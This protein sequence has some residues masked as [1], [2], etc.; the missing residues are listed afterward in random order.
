MAV[1]DHVERLLQPGL[2]CSN[3]RCLCGTTSG[4]PPACAM[5]SCASRS[6]SR[7]SITARR[8]VSTDWRQITAEMCA[9]ARTDY[10]AIQ[11]RRATEDRHSDAATSVVLGR[12]IS[13]LSARGSSRFNHQDRTAGPVRFDRGVGLWHLLNPV[14]NGGMARSLAQARG[15]ACRRPPSGSTRSLSGKARKSSR[16]C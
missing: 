9:L 13:F 2:P 3:V 4:S 8:V 7:T 1:R 10:P 11:G 14:G 15:A 12:P 6:A 5:P 16:W